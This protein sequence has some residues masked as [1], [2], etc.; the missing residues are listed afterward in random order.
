MY[1]LPYLVKYTAYQFRKQKVLRLIVTYISCYVTTILYVRRDR[2]YDVQ[3]M[4]HVELE[5]L[6]SINRKSTIVPIH[7]VKA[8]RVWR[9]NSTYS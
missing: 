5:F 4:L 3:L 1:T 2:I 6:H 9:Y 8:H 7:A